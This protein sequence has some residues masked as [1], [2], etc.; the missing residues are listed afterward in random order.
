MAK[1]LPKQ[2][3]NALVWVKG[4][5]LVVVFC[6]VAVA[7][8]VG[9]FL[10]QGAFGSSVQKRAQERADLYSKVAAAQK[11]SFTLPIPGGETVE[12][13]GRPSPELLS[14][15]EMAMRRLE[16]D[17]S[18]IAAAARDFNR[19]T[20]SRPKHAPLVERKVFPAYNPGTTAADRVRFD[21]VDAVVTSYESLLKD[22]RAGSPPAPATVAEAIVAQEQRSLQSEFSVGSRSKLTAEQAKQ[23]DSNLGK[24]RVAQYA[25]AAKAFAMYSDLSAFEIPTKA[26]VQR[27][28]VKAKDER[29]AHDKLLWE[30]Q[31]KY[32]ISADVM[33]GF[34]RANEDSASVLS[35]PLKR[36]LSVRVLP[37]E[38]A[39]SAEQASGEAS[40]MTAG[41]GSAEG[42]AAEDPSEGAIPDAPAEA[43]APAAVE[44]PLGPPAIDI[45]QAVNREFAK[46]YT[47]RVTNGVYDVRLV[48]AVF[49]AETSRLPV[50]FDAL[51]RQ[52]FMT[53]VNVR[54]APADPFAAARDG[55][56]YGQEPVS[57]VTA[58]IETIWLREWTAEHMP[59]AVRTALGIAEKAPEAAAEPAAGEA[60]GM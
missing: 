4:N 57:T 13:E 36:V 31:W 35:A 54:L 5:T 21:M 42:A 51:A 11:E 45:A 19:G 58:V 37:P 59:A 3:E 12:L 34:A 1:Q 50:I 15:Y 46:R 18:E 55:F 2:V 24:F 16:G 56:L 30:L 25:D 27:L 32:W 14:N 48:E 53:V 23:L 17:A 28:R 22:V 40:A 7:V 39:G 49:V 44:A 20:A 10:A 26:M 8:P 47:G 6:A 60:Q 38:T 9:A 33:R 43:A 52:N 41:E 29:A